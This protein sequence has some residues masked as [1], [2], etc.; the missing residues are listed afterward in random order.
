MKLEDAFSN[1]LVNT[2]RIRSDEA[3]PRL[4]SSKCKKIVLSMNRGDWLLVS[5]SR[6]KWLSEIV[7]EL[8]GNS[9]MYKTSEMFHCFKILEAPWMNGVTTS[10]AADEDN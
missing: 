8:G 3:P 2:A 1:P 5:K 7:R 9:T 4:G 10:K 6:A